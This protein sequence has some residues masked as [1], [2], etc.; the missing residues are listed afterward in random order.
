M[1][2][3]EV[4]TYL[5]QEAEGGQEEDAGDL[6][7]ERERSDVSWC[8]VWTE[9]LPATTPALVVTSWPILPPTH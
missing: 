7:E 2:V 1:T 3:M 8:D 6:H 4:V 9:P 5:G